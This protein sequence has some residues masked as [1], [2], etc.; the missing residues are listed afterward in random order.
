MC[1]L[2]VSPALFFSVKAKIALPSL[3]ADLRSASEDVRAALI[4]SKALEAGNASALMSVMAVYWHVRKPIH[5]SWE[6][7][8]ILDVD[9]VTVWGWIYESEARV[10]AIEYKQVTLRRERNLWEGLNYL[11]YCKHCFEYRCSITC[12]GRRSGLFL[13][14]PPPTSQEDC[15]FDP[16]DDPEYHRRRIATNESGFWTT[17]SCEE[18]KYQT[19]YLWSRGVAVSIFIRKTV[20]SG[21]GGAF[22]WKCFCPWWVSESGIV[23]VV[24]LDLTYLA[25]LFCFIVVHNFL[26]FSQRS[27]FLKTL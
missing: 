18:L 9:Y 22:R 4:S 16:Y 20:T 13:G 12:L 8:W 7:S 27:A 23:Q 26:R 19:K 6:T 2:S 21:G 1:Q 17:R 25:T 5:R 11:L 10:R 3:M 14:K 24:L 15:L